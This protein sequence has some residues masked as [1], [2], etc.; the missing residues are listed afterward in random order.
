MPLT[1]QDINDVNGKCTKIWNNILN[2]GGGN[3]VYV[4][5]GTIYAETANGDGTF[6]NYEITQRCCLI[7]AKSA[8]NNPNTPSNVNPQNIYFDLDEQK[9]RWSEEPKNACSTENTP[10]KIVLNPVGNDGAFFTLTENDTCSLKVK[11]NYLFKINCEVL[12]D[13]IS[14][15]AANPSFNV[16][17]NDELLILRQSKFELESNSFDINNEL[18]NLVQQNAKLNYSI[19]CNEFPTNDEILQSTPETKISASQTLPFTN[20]GFGSLTNTT[21][22]SLTNT[23]VGPVYKTKTVNFCLTEIGLD[24]WRQVIGED[25]YSGFIN[26]VADSYTCLDVVSIY[27]LNK[28]AVLNNQPE[29]LFECNTPFGEKTRTLNRIEELSKLK[30]ENKTKQDNVDVKIKN[31]T[32]IKDT[33]ACSTLLGQFENLSATVTLDLVNDNGTTTQFYSQ[34]LFNQ[35]GNLYNYLSENI[36][37][38]GFLVCGEASETETWASG[39]T[40]LIYPEF[41]NG[42][43]TVD[44]ESD[45]IN[46]SICQIVKET[47]YSE[48]YNNSGL[49]ST[50]DFNQSLS[51]N[52]FNSNWLTYETTIDDQAIITGITNNQIKLNVIINSSCGNLCL[53]VDQINMTKVCE[54]ANRTNIFI[55]QSPGFNLTRVIDNKKSWLQADS[56]TERDFHIGNYN[57]ANQ[58][59][60]TEYTVDEE[61]LILN[62]KEIDLTMNMVSAIEND[63][64]CYLVDN[65]NLLTGQTCS[66][67]TGLTPTDIYGNPI[68]LPT[69]QTSSTIITDKAYSINFSQT[70]T[71]TGYPTTYTFNITGDSKVGFVTMDYNAIAQP[72]RFMVYDNGAFKLDSGNIGSLN[73]NSLSTTERTNLKIRLSGRTNPIT[74]SVYP[75]ASGGT[76][77]N[78]ILSD[79]F[80][81]VFQPVSGS[82][83]YDKTSLNSSFQVRVYNAW[84]GE[85]SGWNLNV[86]FTPPTDATYIVSL[87]NQYFESCVEANYPYIDVCYPEIEDD[88]CGST[89]KILLDNGDRS[90][91]VTC[92]DNGELGFY[93]ITGNTNTQNTIYNITDFMLTP[94]GLSELNNF[95]DLLNSYIVSANLDIPLY[96]SFWNLDGTCNFCNNTCG[97]KRIDFSGYM[98]TNI[99]EIKTLESFDDLM[100]SELID[101]KNRKTLSSYPSLRAVYDRYM[102]ATEYGLTN[103]N[104]FDYYKMDQFT[105]LVKT[106]WDDL[107]EQVVPSTTIWGNVKVYTN[108]LF[109]QQKFKYR[110]YTTLFGL[111]SFYNMNIPSPINGSDGQCKDIEIMVQNV[112]TTSG[113]TSYTSNKQTFNS[114]CISQMN[115]GSEFIGNVQIIKG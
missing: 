104:E 66:S 12:K 96:Q 92:Q 64:W 37:N 106:Y 59:R 78:E 55:S 63:V 31:I 98:S 83:S 93:Y 44:P 49:V 22:L 5:D 27:E 73:Y 53:L 21:D 89:L 58:I 113:V 54:D 47:L 28:T 29:L 87:A 68:I 3:I 10:I 50:S 46:V 48:L 2:Y 65:P 14:G 114:V 60:Q 81:K 72:D 102:D 26:G 34:T 62:T 40:G 61:R 79:G 17:S 94:T 108:T 35:I 36:D 1:Q 30:I 76:G 38:S 80:P 74:S 42:V 20:T 100:T 77:V 97:D 13:I 101:V 8:T 57:D 88:L 18:D 86:T 56:Y 41:T 51:P 7:L 9:C 23:K 99:S 91:W 71:T 6:T 45:N 111:N 70:G 85:S 109:D 52:A 15:P 105:S 4:P 19:V 103:S 32:D 84:V 112:Q 107:I 16:A 90:L 69:A 39:C 67:S 75:N 25:N 115:W 11:F 24:S 43:L 110:S 95:I 33:N 82:L